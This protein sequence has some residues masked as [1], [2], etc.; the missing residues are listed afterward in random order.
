[1]KTKKN[2]NRHKKQKSQAILPG[3]AMNENEICGLIPSLLPETEDP[4][5]D[6]YLARVGKK[7]EDLFLVAF[8]RK[9]LEAEAMVDIKTACG[10]QILRGE[11]PDREIVA[12]VFSYFRD[13]FKLL[14]RTDL[15]PLFPAILEEMGF[16]SEEERIHA[17]WFDFLPDFIKVFTKKRPDL[18]GMIL[19]Q[20][21]D[22]E[23][24]DSQKLR[25]V[26]QSLLLQSL[27]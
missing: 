23:K 5:L 8:H 11:K 24:K 10:L 4:V 25:E 18:V 26:L 14:H 19:K 7:S 17:L 27:T 9:Y 6:R 22:C 12:L 16:Q 1:M 3:F 2:T 13:A 15:H 20:C 21:Y